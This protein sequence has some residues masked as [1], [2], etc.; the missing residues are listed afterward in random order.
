M[1]A[2]GVGWIA[3]GAL[4]FAF[5]P[6][7]GDNEYGG[8]TQEQ[9]DRVK[10]DGRNMLLAGPVLTAVFLP[11]AIYGRRQVGACRAAPPASSASSS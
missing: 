11:S 10:T 6:D 7:V 5:P 4:M 8:T 9:H 1:A 3:I 2:M